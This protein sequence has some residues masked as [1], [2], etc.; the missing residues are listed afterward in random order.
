MFV[1][2][3]ILANGQTVD[4]AKIKLLTVDTYDELRRNQETHGI[5]KLTYY[6]STFQYQVEIPNW[7]TLRETGTGDAIAGTLPAIDGIENAISVNGFRKDNFS[8]FEDFQRIFIT[9]N[10]FGKE[11]LFGKNYIWYGRNERDFKKIEHGVTSRVFIF[12]NRV[13]YHNQFVLLETKSAYLWIQ[14][15]ATPDTF[16]TNLPKFNE[17][18]KGLKVM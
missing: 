11:A 12:F 8:S 15:I 4:S 18:L 9:G 14:F 2:L 3:G 10:T 5:E 13:I 16:D 1:L 7:L 17:F 6:D